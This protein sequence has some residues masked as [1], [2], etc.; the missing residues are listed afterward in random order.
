[1][2]IFESNEHSIP[3]FSTVFDVIV[4]V[5]EL[6]TVTE[7]PEIQKDAIRSRVMSWRTT[8][9]LLLR[10][11]RPFTD[12]TPVAKTVSVAVSYTRLHVSFPSETTT[13]PSVISHVGAAMAKP[14]GQLASTSQKHRNLWADPANCDEAIVSIHSGELE[15]RN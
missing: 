3:A 7:L 10:I 5:P 1:M 4:F 12:E 2:V 13:D 11:P 9:T 15:A 14:V 6:T 8:M